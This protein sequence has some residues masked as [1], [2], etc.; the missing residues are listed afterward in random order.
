[1]E[2][3]R[4]YGENF[5][6]ETFHTEVELV[7]SS[8]D[9]VLYFTATKDIFVVFNEKGNDYANITEF[10]VDDLVPFITGLQDWFEKHG[11]SEE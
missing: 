10:G 5:V 4:D 7:G 11:K 8:V 2:T 6:L 1:M 3:I 9:K